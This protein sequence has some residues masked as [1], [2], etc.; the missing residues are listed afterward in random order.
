MA[1]RAERDRLFAKEHQLEF[2]V[3]LNDRHSCRAFGEVL[4]GYPC[5]IWEYTPLHCF[6]Y[7]VIDK[8][9]AE[10]IFEE[11]PATIYNAIALYKILTAY[12]ERWSW[13][14]QEPTT[15]SSTSL[16]PCSAADLTLA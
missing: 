12:S 15:G 7:V 1:N 13:S 4:K 9:V 11:V 8:D 5:T 16:S 3:S 10:K 2:V 6:R 14:T